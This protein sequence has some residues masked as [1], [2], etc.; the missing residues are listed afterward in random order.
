MPPQPSAYNLL[1]LYRQHR[2]EIDAITDPVTLFTLAYV[3]HLGEVRLSALA[4]ELGLSSAG[5]NK[6]LLPLYRGALI[7]EAGEMLRLTPLGKRVLAELGFVAPPVSP[8]QSSEPSKPPTPSPKPPAPPAAGLAGAGFLGGVAL[9]LI[10]ALI[11]GAL[12]LPGVLNPPRL[13]PTLAP[14]VIT[15]PPATIPYAVPEAATQ[16]I[17]RTPTPSH[18]FTPTWTNTFTPTPSLTLTSTWTNTFTPTPSRTPTL[19]R[20]FTPTRTRTPTLD[21]Q[22]PPAP[23]TLSLSGGTLVSCSGTKTLRWSSV[24]DLAGIARYEW[25]LE[26][27]DLRFGHYAPAIAGA[28][29]AFGFG[30]DRF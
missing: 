7:T 1:Q 5:L 13:P 16:V 29:Y 20:T 10:G 26:G 4:R 28:R 3:N 8:T 17:E 19:T 30:L 23:T 18:T 6:T 11:V 25:V 12:V 27:D 2:D 24:S 15:Q 21:T 14:L 22:G 9:V